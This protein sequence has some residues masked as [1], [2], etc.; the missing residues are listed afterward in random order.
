M[1]Q[2]LH[3]QDNL[4]Q[5]PIQA[6]RTWRR[7]PRKEMDLELPNKSQCRRNATLGCNGQYRRYLFGHF[8]RQ[9]DLQLYVEHAM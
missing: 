6:I 4:A 3:L 7:R 8:N 2:Q 1:I 5:A 9:Y